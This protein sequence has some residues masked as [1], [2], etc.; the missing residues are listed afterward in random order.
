MM[1]REYQ[2]MNFPSFTKVINISMVTILSST[3]TI[4]LKQ[5]FIMTYAFNFLPRAQYRGHS[6]KDFQATRILDNSVAWLLRHVCI[7]SGI[8]SL[9]L[10]QRRPDHC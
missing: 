2:S 5:A 1:Y 6:R 9:S 8:T 7:I 3:N 10:R 4:T